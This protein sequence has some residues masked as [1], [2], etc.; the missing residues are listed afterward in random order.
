MAD[1][2]APAGKEVEMAPGVLPISRLIVLED[3]DYLGSIRQAYLRRMME[4]TGSAS[5]FVLVAR[6][7]S[8]I[9]DA[10]RSRTQMIRIPSTSRATMLDRMRTVAE[11]EG[12]GAA[13][14]VLEDIAYI[15]KGNLRKA[16]FTLEMLHIRGLARDR[17]AV[18]RLVQATTL[19]SGRHLLELALR[20]R[21][22]EW[23][24]ESRGGRKKR[25]LAGAL[26]E[27]DRL[28]NDHGLDSDD[29][30]SQLHDVLVG[31][32]LSLPDALREE[33]LS[34]LADCDAQL[35]RSMHARIPFENFLH[36]VARAG[37]THGLAFG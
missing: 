30:V 16:L 23:R 24:W 18:H 37:H 22:V 6:A 36:K 34:A 9:I 11:T 12:V 20:G 3:A 35:T 27:V 13:D 8:R 14:G 26:A 1:D 10:L 17:S 4:T 21:V 28:M 19:Q 25:I 29:V 15:S 33:V 7:P 5:R 31:R 2:V 32:R